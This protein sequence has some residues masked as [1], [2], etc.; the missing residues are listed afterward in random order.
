MG[1]E[2][3][4]A[5]RLSAMLMALGSAG[6]STS[7]RDDVARVQELS[8]VRVAP[9]DFDGEVDTVT[10]ANVRTA[11]AAPLDADAAVRIALANNRALR[12]ELRELGVARG[13]LLQAGL[14]PNPRLEIEF[15]PERNTSVELR[16]EYDLRGILLAPLRSRAARYD[17]QAAHYRAAAAV[18]TLGFETRSAFYALQAAEEQVAVAQRLLDAFAAGRDYARA[19][20]EAG[21]LPPVDAT[22][23]DAAYQ[24]AR[25]T[26]AELEL[27]ALDRREE[28]H[29]M[30]G[31]HGD[32][33]RWTT[34]GA[35]GP[36]PATLAVEENAETR[37]LTASLEAGALRSQMEGAARRAG[38]ARVAGLI[39]EL[40]GDVHVLAGDP[41]QR[42]GFDSLG[43]NWTV[44]AGVGLVLPLFDRQQGRVRE[45]L[46]EFDAAMER[47]VGLGIDLRSVVRETRNR[48]ASTHARA[49]QYD[50][51]ILPARAQVLE[52]TLRQYNA[53]QTGVLQLLEARRAQLDAELSAI[54][55]RR[56][57]WTAAAAFQALLAGA[58]INAHGEGRR[59]TA[60]RGILGSSVSRGE[61]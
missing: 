11:L 13:R 23:Q 34:R 31:V 46:A 10:N 41:A 3:S 49:R 28:M 56:A 12:A 36:A 17:L 45:F 32:E 60:G 20:V 2:V 54:H 44:G 50:D 48:L 29:R 7:I 51:V 21:N 5:L 8:R 40:T 35:L 25:I 61:R 55:T 59:E 42:S 43:R 58:R 37:A 14:L 52:Q 26:V 30:L 16:V 53:M 6:C 4:G 27:E 15:L 18:V 38:V 19:L 33:T 39:P 1:R 57:F 22:T 47:Y 24:E 9:D